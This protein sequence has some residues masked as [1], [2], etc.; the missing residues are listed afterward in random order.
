MESHSLFVGT[1]DAHLVQAHVNVFRIEA[2]FVCTVPLVEN[3]VHVLARS[4]LTAEGTSHVL[5][6]LQVNFVFE[7]VG[8]D[9][10]RSSC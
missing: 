9:L 4:V 1:F 5:D 6:G 2:A 10:S 3:F 7:R 8:F